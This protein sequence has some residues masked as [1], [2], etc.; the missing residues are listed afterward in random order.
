[1]ALD[2]FGMLLLQVTVILLV[3]AIVDILP[4]YLELDNKHKGGKQK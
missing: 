4:L 1:M 3:I 2:I